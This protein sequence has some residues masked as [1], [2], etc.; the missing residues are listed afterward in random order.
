[1]NRPTEVLV[2]IAAGVAII[3]GAVYIGTHTDVNC[4]NWFGLAKGCAATVH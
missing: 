3:V 2:A 1:M 4:F